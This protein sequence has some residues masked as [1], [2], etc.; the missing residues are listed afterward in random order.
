MTN[1]TQ[2]FLVVVGINFPK[3]QRRE[4]GDIVTAAEL[5]KTSISHLVARGHIKPTKED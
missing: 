2:S 3:G 1:S 4:P 5:P